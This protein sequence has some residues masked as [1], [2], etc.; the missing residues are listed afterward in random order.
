MKLENSKAIEIISLLNSEIEK[1]LKK[2]NYYNFGIA[3]DYEEFFKRFPQLGTFECLKQE[4]V[5]V[6]R[7]AIYE[8]FVYQFEN[9]EEPIG[10]TAPRF[11][12]SGFYLPVS[13]D[14]HFY[15]VREKM[16][17]TWERI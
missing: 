11:E 15:R 5:D 13:S 6:D 7:S 8:E 16:L 17:K 2:A 14:G 10:F 3:F 12:D 4:I 9:C 1:A